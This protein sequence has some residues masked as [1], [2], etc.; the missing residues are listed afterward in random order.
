MVGLPGVLFALLAHTIREPLRG[1]LLRTHAGD[2]SRLSLQQSAR[3]I[4]RRWQSLLG[5]SIGAIFQ[6]VPTYALL[7]WTPTYFQRVH[8]WTAGQSGRGSPYCC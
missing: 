2:A 8:G 7:S 1:D 6:A 4:G 3:E 5:I